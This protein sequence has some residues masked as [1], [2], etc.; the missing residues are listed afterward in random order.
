MSATVEFGSESIYLDHKRISKQ[1]MCLTHA[2]PNIEVCD[3]FHALRKDASCLCRQSDYVRKA[4]P[5][6]VNVQCWAHMRGNYFSR[7][8]VNTQRLHSRE[9]LLSSERTLQQWECWQ[10]LFWKLCRAGRHELR[11]TVLCVVVAVVL[12]HLWHRQGLPRQDT[13]RVR[14]S[15]SEGT[16]LC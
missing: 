11:L 14:V 16:Q 4:R 5:Y 7:A 6:L 2:H 3:S 8:F 15:L 9:I 10:P 1:C 13:E 12:L